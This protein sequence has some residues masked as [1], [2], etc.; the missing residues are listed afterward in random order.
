MTS[1]M[2]SR[3]AEDLILVKTSLIGVTCGDNTL[4][5]LFG[6]QYPELMTW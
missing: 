1:A 6:Q 4:R 5:A 2:E 3:A